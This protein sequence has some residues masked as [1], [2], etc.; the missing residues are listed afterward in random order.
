[1][2]PECTAAYD[3]FK[4]QLMTTE[5]P[6]RALERYYGNLRFKKRKG[7]F[8]YQSEDLAFI[9]AVAGNLA[10]TL[11]HMDLQSERR[12]QQLREKN[13][14]LLAE[15]AEL[16]ALR[17]QINPHFLFN[18]LNSLAELSQSDPRATEAAILN[19]SHVFRYALDAS[20]HESVI[21]EDELRFIESYL[22]I[23]R[24]RFEEGL[25]YEIKASAEARICSIPP[26]MIQPIVENAVRHGISRKVGGGQ[27]KIFASLVEGKLQVLVE[28]DGLGFDSESFGESGQSGVGLENVRGRLERIGQAGSLQITSRPNVGTKVRLMLA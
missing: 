20:Q 28:D 10:A 16:R 24:L 13:L 4:H 17:A 5:I 1:M 23:E 9:T 12:A 2:I 27:V 22:E 11:R 6:V 7:R 8:Q 18:A 15:Q 3:A 26:M 21:L 14:Q 25:C 19:L